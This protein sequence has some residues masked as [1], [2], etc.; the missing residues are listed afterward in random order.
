MK[1]GK[2]ATHWAKWLKRECKGFSDLLAVDPYRHWSRFPRAHGLAETRLDF[3]LWMALSR[4]QGSEGLALARTAVEI[5]DRALAE[6]ILRRGKNRSHHPFYEGLAHRCRAYATFLC[7]LPLPVDSLAESAQ[8][9]VRWFSPGA[10]GK[11]VGDLEIY[12]ISALSSAL[13]SGASTCIAQIRPLVAKLGTWKQHQ[14]VFLALC[15]EATIKSDV[16]HINNDLFTSFDKLF[17]GVRKPAAARTLL[18]FELACLRCWLSCGDV[19][20]LALTDVIE[21][22]L[23]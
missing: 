17:D 3:A 14:G 20:K 9:I 15:D 2:Y 7:G 10:A 5:C 11:L 22:L 6:K 21:L 13:M 4:Y 19:N 12:I 23:Y 1:S 18:S 16:Q 8:C